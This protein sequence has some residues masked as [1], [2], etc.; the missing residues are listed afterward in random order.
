MK[1]VALIPAFNEEERI[2]STVRALAE[3]AS[4]DE[5]IVINDGSTDHTRQLVEEE[6]LRLPQLHVV[7]LGQNQGKGAA[8]NQG[9]A[10]SEADVYL[11]L[12]ADLGTTARHAQ[13]LL[14][15][16]LSGEVQMTIGR[17]STGQSSGKMGFGLV[18]RLAALGIWLLTGFWV[19]SPLSGQRAVAAEVLR[20]LGGFSP[21][22]GV[23][24]GLTVGALHHGFKIREVPVPMQH[25]AYGRG[26]QGFKHRG[27]QLVHVL[28]ALWRCWR[29]G[30]HR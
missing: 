19:R 2:G 23:E 8:L 10:A 22:F 24:V 1:V 3:L 12:D 11:L 7:N 18:R 4:L 13:L 29:K 30:W 9:W 5:I 21:G 26:W 20:T 14:D 6:Q 16:V 25:R 27:R 17:F 15:P 28:G